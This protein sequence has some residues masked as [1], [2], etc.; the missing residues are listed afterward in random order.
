[1]SHDLTSVERE[2]EFLYVAKCECGH[3]S[4]AP[5]PDTARKRHDIHASIYHARA[6]LEEGRSGG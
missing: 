2:R 6:A 5:N 1:M 4:K 3:E